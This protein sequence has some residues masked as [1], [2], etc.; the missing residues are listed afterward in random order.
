MFRSAAAIAGP[1]GRSLRCYLLHVFGFD[2]LAGGPDRSGTR[3]SLL[4]TKI[5]NTTSYLADLEN[6]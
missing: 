5:N 2:R 4:E 6:G 3:N 1:A